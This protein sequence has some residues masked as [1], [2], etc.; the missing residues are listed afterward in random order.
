[1]AKIVLTYVGVLAFLCVVGGFFGIDSITLN[2]PWFVLVLCAG[3]YGIIKGMEK[4][5]GEKK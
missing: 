4:G 1:M 3:F 5:K 2:A